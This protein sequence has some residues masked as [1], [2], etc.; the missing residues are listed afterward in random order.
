QEVEAFLSDLAVNR[1]VAPGTQKTALCALVFLYGTFLNKPLVDMQITR[2]KRN[3]RVPEV[4]SH[5]EAKAVIDKLSDIY[6]VMALLMY[7]AG[8]RI[9]E[10]LRLRVKDINFS[11]GYIVVREGKGLKDRR[12]L[13]PESLKEPLQEQIRYVKSLFEFDRANNL[14]GVYMPYALERKY[15]QASTQL[16]WQFLFPAKKPSIDPRSGLIRRHHIIDRTL[17]RQVRDAIRRAQITRQCSSHTFRHSFATR[18]PEKG[19]DIRTIQELMGHTDVKTTE[20]YTHVI[21][22]GG[23]GVNSPIDDM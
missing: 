17:Q 7:G 10:C 14:S 19:Y 9:N 2:S 15:P 18:L 16:A 21:G 4:F 1:H 8:L 3:V 6:R 20:I 11:M 23:L 5:N 13:L 12:T 22:K